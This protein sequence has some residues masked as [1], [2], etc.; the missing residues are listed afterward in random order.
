MRGTWMRQRECPCPARR[1]SRFLLGLTEDERVTKHAFMSTVVIEDYRDKF[2]KLL[3]TLVP[4]LL[5]A[6]IFCEKLIIEAEKR[7]KR[8]LSEL[9]ERINEVGGINSS[10]VRP[11]IS[12][13]SSQAGAL[14][15]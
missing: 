10:A 3:G 11:S 15:S 12:L 9:I 8:F 1:G 4:N 7:S 14:K 2:G 13:N 5:D 6:K